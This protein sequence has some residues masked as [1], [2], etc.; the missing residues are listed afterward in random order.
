MMD[1]PLSAARVRS[2]AAVSLK[3]TQREKRETRLVRRSLPPRTDALRG[4]EEGRLTGS[5]CVGCHGVSPCLLELLIPVVEELRRRSKPLAPGDLEEVLPIELLEPVVE[6][7]A[8]DLTE[9]V[10]ANLDD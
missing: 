3:L 9:D 6:H 7:R 5:R 2:Q 1:T 8:V 10:L 4:L